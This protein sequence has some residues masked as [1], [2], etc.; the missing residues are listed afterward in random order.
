MSEGGVACVNVIPRE[1]GVASLSPNPT[2]GGVASVPFGFSEGEK[3]NKVLVDVTGKSP[4][5]YVKKVWPKSLLVTS[6]Q[7]KEVW[8]VC[9]LKR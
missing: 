1:G 6:S 2:K 4:S 8:P 3:E 7:V 5:K 9:L